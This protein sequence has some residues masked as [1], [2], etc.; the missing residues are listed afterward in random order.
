SDG[1]LPVRAT[2]PFSSDAGASPNSSRLALGMSNTSDSARSIR[3]DGEL[4]PRS[5]WL[6]KP[7]DIWQ[8]LAS[9][10][11]D[12]PRFLRAWRICWPSHRSATLRASEPS[13]GGDIQLHGW[14]DGNAF[15]HP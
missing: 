2:M 10:E 11:I 5:T 4:I 9:S 3:R 7:T 15:F 12:R 8:A 6:S 13:A 14:F 1:W